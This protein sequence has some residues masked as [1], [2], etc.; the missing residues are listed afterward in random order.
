[1][2]IT[3]RGTL[4]Y[5]AKRGTLRR[6]GKINNGKQKKQ[7]NDYTDNMVRSLHLDAVQSLS[8]E[9]LPLLDACAA[10]LRHQRQWRESALLKKPVAWSSSLASILS[11]TSASSSL[12]AVRS[13]D[14][15]RPTVLEDEQCSGDVEFRGD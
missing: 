13:T 10:T 5:L 6:D 15:G 8:N 9:T 4:Y 7:R 2:C 11:P 1:M 12:E 14:G 3:G